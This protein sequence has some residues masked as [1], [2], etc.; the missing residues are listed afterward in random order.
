[1]ILASEKV[2]NNDDLRRQIWN[3]FKKDSRVRCI[4]C[5]NLY[6]EDKMLRYPYKDATVWIDQCKTCAWT[7]NTR[8]ILGK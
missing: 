7:A 4:T 1:M 3:Y 5:R 8:D 6:K 2:M